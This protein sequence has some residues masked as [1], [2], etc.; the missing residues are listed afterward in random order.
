[1]VQ[2]A[3]LV[4]VLFAEVVVEILGVVDIAL[5]VVGAAGVVEAWYEVD[6]GS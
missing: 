5:V 6:I 4:V 3:A 1:M 2:P